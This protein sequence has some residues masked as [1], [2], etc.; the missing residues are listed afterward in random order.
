MS[1]DLRYIATNRFLVGNFLDSQPLKLRRL[2]TELE[3]PPPEK[4]TEKS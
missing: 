3:Q 4:L 2:L 1:N